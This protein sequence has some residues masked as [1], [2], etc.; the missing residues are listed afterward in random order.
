[1]GRERLGGRKK[2]IGGGRG[3]DWEGEKRAREKG[4]V[5]ET[6]GLKLMH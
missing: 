1:M 2:V 6:L 4:D 5:S 3:R